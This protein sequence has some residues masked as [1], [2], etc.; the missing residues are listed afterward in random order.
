M[1]ERFLAAF[2][3][4]RLDRMA[5]LTTLDQ[6]IQLPDGTIARGRLR[7]ARLIAWVI[8]RSRGTLQMTPLSVSAQGECEVVARTHNTAKRGKLTLDLEMTLVFSLRDRRVSAV[9]ETVEDLSAWRR[10]W[11]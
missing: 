4:H 8:W 9:N 1:V 3:H 11:R 10:F 2:N 6:T 5:R 7:V